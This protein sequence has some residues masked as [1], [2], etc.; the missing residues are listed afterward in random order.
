MNKNLTV[1]QN[2]H[3]SYIYATLSKKIFDIEKIKEEIAEVTYSNLGI[4]E[5]LSNG[6]MA[7]EENA[8]SVWN[9]T[10]RLTS[11]YNYSTFVEYDKNAKFNVR[12][13][14][15]EKYIYIGF[16]VF[17]DT[18]LKKQVDC[19]DGG[20]VSA[21]RANGEKIDSYV[22]TYIG[23]NILNMSEYYGY[24]SGIFKS[25]EPFAFYL[26]DGSP[27]RIQKPKGFRESFYFHYDDSKEKRYYFHV[28][29]IAFQD[30]KVKCD[31]AMP[32]GSFVYYSDRYGRVGWK[33]NGLWA[34]QGFSQFKL[35]P[36]EKIC[37]K[38][39]E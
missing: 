10:K 5:I 13:L 35:L 3:I 27:H 15:D 2:R 19:L 7:I 37:D 39:G 21:Y 12:L 16:Q 1:E 26:N 31:D 18:L 9:K 20:F 30:L 32:Y 22:E 17:D 24:V 14:Y 25:R 29:A 28:Q 11:F 36:K 34:K 23:G 8:E 33:G 38:K 4:D 6:Q